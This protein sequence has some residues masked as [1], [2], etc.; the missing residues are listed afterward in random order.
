MTATVGG[1]AHHYFG[2]KTR[3][4]EITIKLNLG[5]NSY[6]RTEYGQ[7]GVS[8]LSNLSIADSLNFLKMAKKTPQKQ[9]WNF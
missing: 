3:D 2:V 1:S 8:E 6:L 5:Q 4:N 9:I 7:T